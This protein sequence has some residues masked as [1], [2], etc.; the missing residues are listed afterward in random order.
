MKPQ[1]DFQTSFMKNNSS[2]NPI[3]CDVMKSDEDKFDVCQ[4][5]IK[6]ELTIVCRRNVPQQKT[7]VFFIVSKSVLNS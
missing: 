3:R 7:A 4:S 5:S 1:M 6:F 2:A